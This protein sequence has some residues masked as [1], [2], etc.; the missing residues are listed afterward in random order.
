LSGRLTAE[1]NVH[2]VETV[3]VRD[4]DE[5]GDGVLREV[6][7][8]PQLGDVLSI[9]ASDFHIS[10]ARQVDNRRRLRARML[11]AD[12]QESQQRGGSY[13]TVSASRFA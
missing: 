12:Q 10:I 8:Q 5:P 13:P 7:D 2:V 4:R 1:I 11:S 3:D 9:T 6:D